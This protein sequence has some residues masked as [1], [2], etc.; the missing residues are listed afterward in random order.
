[1]I[2]DT[3]LK[4]EQFRRGTIGSHTKIVHV[5]ASAAPDVFHE[6]RH[7]FNHTNDLISFSDT[8]NNTIQL[9][10]RTQSVA[11]TFRNGTQKTKYLPKFY[12]NY[13]LTF[14]PAETN[15]EANWRDIFT[16]Q[17]AVNLTV[18]QEFAGT[19]DYE[20]RIR[21]M[22]QLIKLRHFGIHVKPKYST[23]DLKE[24][25]ETAPTLQ[26]ARIYFPYDPTNEYA[27]EL[28]RNQCLPPY[29]TISSTANGVIQFDKLNAPDHRPCWQKPNFQLE[30]RLNRISPI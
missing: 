27:E 23:L 19:S 30:Q 2:V 25:Y 28:A 6:A 7:F 1:M 15:N 5:S 26:S 12:K 22:R 21:G 10:P 9:E 4:L 13:V 11:A 16:F 17:N 8:T 18:G 20:N 29:W 3:P 24:F 14:S